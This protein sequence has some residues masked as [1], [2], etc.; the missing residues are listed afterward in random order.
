MTSPSLSRKSHRRVDR[1][2]LRTD[3]RHLVFDAA[4]ALAVTASIFALLYWRVET[5]ASQTLDVMPELDDARVYWLYWACQAFGWSALL[6]AWVSVVFGLARSMVPLRSSPFSHAQIE[7][8]HRVTSIT[9][10]LLMLAHALAFFAEKV[11]AND[12][13]LGPVPRFLTAL[14]DTFVPGHYSSGTGEVAILIGLIALYL[15]IPLGLSFY[16]RSWTGSR[17]W[18]VLHRFVIM[19]YVL[20]VWHTL[21]YGTNVWFD[22]WFR[23]LVW[24]LQLPVALLFLAR[25]LR[26]LRQDERLPL[27]RVAKDPGPGVLVR[28]AGRVLTAAGVVVLLL[29]TVT[30]RDGGRT[31]G[32]EPGDMLVPQPMVWGGLAV[33]STV[34]GAVAL[35]R[36]PRRPVPSTQ[37][38]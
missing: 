29:A 19:V 21:L 31:P 13:G 2:T 23:T 11:R 18:R 14:A 25:L 24:A 32:E 7:R 37:V 10:M 5:S 27:R 12:D 35:A 3:L 8:W 9:T 15:A 28:L 36:W 34:M 4:L 20:S 26:P 38:V 33:L 6:W 16:V 30:G 1:R 22:G 17:F